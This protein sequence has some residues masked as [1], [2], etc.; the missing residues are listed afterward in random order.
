MVL[1][2][3]TAV[4]DQPSCRLS[5]LGHSRRRPAGLGVSASPRSHLAVA[6]W[7]FRSRAWARTAG[8]E[9]CSLRSRCRRC[10]A[11]SITAICSLLLSPTAF[12][13]SLALGL[14]PP[15]SARPP[16]ALVVCPILWQKGALGVVAV[17]LVVAL[18]MLTWR[19]ASIYQRQRNLLSP[20][21]RAQPAGPGYP[22]HSLGKTSCISKNGMRK[23]SPQPASQ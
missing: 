13:I 9:H 5:A 2:G 21:R 1:R 16:M 8:L 11:L 22:F 4:A 15:S 12:S 17:V 7:Y 20:H 14:W 19:Q 23:P 6:L 10:W 3:Q 18:G